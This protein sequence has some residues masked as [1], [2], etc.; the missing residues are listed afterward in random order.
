MTHAESLRTQANQLRLAAKPLLGDP[1][2]SL[3]AALGGLLVEADI[4]RLKQQ[5]GV[6]IDSMPSSNTINLVT[7]VTGF[8]TANVYEAMADLEEYLITQG[9]LRTVSDKLRESSQLNAALRNSAASGDWTEFDRL[10]ANVVR[11]TSGTTGTS[12]TAGQS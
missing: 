8:V 11:G 6:V 10:T 3:K 7:A 1:S 5:L 9:A 4:D 2:A 12:G